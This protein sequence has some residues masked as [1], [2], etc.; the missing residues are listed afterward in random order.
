[1]IVEDLVREVAKLAACTRRQQ[2]AFVRAARVLCEQSEV[3]I[4]HDLSTGQKF[5]FDAIR[6]ERVDGRLHLVTNGVVREDIKK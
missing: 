5:H 3:V 1:M 6:V 2:E 4:R